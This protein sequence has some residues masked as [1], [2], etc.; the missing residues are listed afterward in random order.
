MEGG[1]EVGGDD[2]RSNRNPREIIHS[3]RQFIHSRR[4]TAK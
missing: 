2:L 3:L 1:G 4:N